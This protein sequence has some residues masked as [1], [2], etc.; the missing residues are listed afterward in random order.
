MRAP[1][2]MPIESRYSTGSTKPEIMMAA[3]DVFVATSPRTITA[4]TL[5]EY[6]EASGRRSA[7]SSR[8]ASLTRLISTLQPSCIDPPGEHQSPTG[9]DQ[10]VDHVH[11]GEPAGFGMAVGQDA[12]QLR[13]VP[14]RGD[15]ADPL[16]EPGQR[17]EREQHPKKQKQQHN[18]KPLNQHKLTLF[19]NH[20]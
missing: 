9:Q 4:R 6:S 19:H 14:D 11:G 15:P 20:H 18:N 2:P 1:R 13:G 10:Q 3:F 16:Q 17:R 5:R 12:A 8:S 7:V